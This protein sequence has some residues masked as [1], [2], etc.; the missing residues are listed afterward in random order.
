MDWESK[1]LVESFLYDAIYFDIPNHKTIAK[2]HRRIQYR[3][4]V[5]R[6]SSRRIGVRALSR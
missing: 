3:C 1:D 2:Y 4:S 6:K 5:H